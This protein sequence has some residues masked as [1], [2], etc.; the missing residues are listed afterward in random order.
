MSPSPSGQGSPSAPASISRSSSGSS[1]SSLEEHGTRRSP[2][3][4]ALSSSSA[5][6]SPSLQCSASLPVPLGS[7]S[8]ERSFA[9]LPSQPSSRSSGGISSM[10]P[11]VGPEPLDLDPN[12][13]IAYAHNGYIYRLAIYR[14]KVQA[15]QTV[16]YSILRAHRHGK[17]ILAS[18]GGDGHVCLW[19]LELG[20]KKR[21]SKLSLLKRLNQSDSDQAIFCLAYSEGTLFAGVSIYLPCC[22]ASET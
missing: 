13:C 20:S 17:V 11:K 10:H 1:L 5:E 22:E 15:A 2:R 16:L 9:P 7:V 14:N 21:F 6:A 8:P 3:L 18:A 19:V 12:A 4:L